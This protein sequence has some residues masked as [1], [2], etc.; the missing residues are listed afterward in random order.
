MYEIGL[1]FIDQQENVIEGCVGKK[2]VAVFKGKLKED[3]VYKIEQFMLTGQKMR[4]QVAEHPYR[5]KLAK[6]TKIAEIVPQ[7]EDFPFYTYRI[8]SFDELEGRIGDNTYMSL[9]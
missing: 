4:N 9:G 8:K 5:I 2:R 3:T 7:P 6:Y 1:L